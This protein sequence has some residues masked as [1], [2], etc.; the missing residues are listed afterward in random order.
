MKKAYNKIAILSFFILLSFLFVQKAGADIYVV[1]LYFDIKTNTLRFD[2]QQKSVDLDKKESIGLKEFFD[3]QD[4]I[5]KADYILKIQPSN[6]TEIDVMK[7]DKHTGQF[8]LKVPF[9]VSGE[10]I[11]I[12]N[13]NSGEKIDSADILSFQTCNSNSICEYEKGENGQTCI[14]DCSTSHNVY[15]AETRDLL[16]K[17]NGVIKDPKSGEILLKDPNYRND[18]IIPESNN[19]SGFT[20]PGTQNNSQSGPVTQVNPSQNVS[21]STE[22][23]SSEVSPTAMILLGIFLLSLLGVLIYLKFIKKI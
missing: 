8:D 17:N 14:S 23:I 16:T 11:N 12:Y 15:S 4:A 3:Q 7:F 19:N 2:N 5:K 1:H 9:F 18:N 21:T 13:F 6:G 22:N 20:S 10:K